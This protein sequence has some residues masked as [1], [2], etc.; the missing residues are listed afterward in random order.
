MVRGR[1]TKVGIIKTGRAIQAANQ[2]H[3]SNQI[4]TGA[5]LRSIARAAQNQ[6]VTDVIDESAVWDVTGRDTHL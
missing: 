4:R 2:M 1:A 6:T 5:G 3:L